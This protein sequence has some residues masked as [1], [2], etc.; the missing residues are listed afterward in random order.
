MALLIH[1][2][3]VLQDEHTGT[4]RHAVGEGVP[5]FNSTEPHVVLRSIDLP[6]LLAAKA[7]EIVFSFLTAQGFRV[8]PPPPTLPGAHIM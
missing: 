6:V 2:V 1:P 7:Q 4:D 8:P 3:D 5:V